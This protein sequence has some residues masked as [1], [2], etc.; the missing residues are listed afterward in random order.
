MRS[1]FW[2][3]KGRLEPMPGS[4]I[5][6]V[7][8]EAIQRA[9]DGPFS[10]TF[11][12]V[13]VEVRADSDPDLIYRDWSRAM[14][15]YIEKQVGPYPSRELSDAERAHDA[16]VEATNRARCDAAQAEYDRKQK[17]KEESA[18][19]KLAGVGPIELLS[20]PAWRECVAKNQDGYGAAVVSYAERWARLMQAEMAAGAA[21]PDIAERL[22]CEADIEGI[23][24]FMYGCAVS[25][26]ATMWK[27]GEALRRWHNTKTQIGTEGDRANESGGVIN[28]ALLSMGGA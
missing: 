21:L 15:G 20:E 7:I 4:N 2:E 25:M 11:N 8:L 14:S 5:S 13:Q 9:N 12:N 6:D 17:A 19:T 26:L 27:H 3:W 28:P 16:E 24:G 22:S 18:A 23:T 1:S 10:F